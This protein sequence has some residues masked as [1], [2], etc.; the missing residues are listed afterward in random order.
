MD[1]RRLRA[2]LA[3]F[4]VES[5]VSPIIQF[6]ERETLERVCVKVHLTAA[7]LEDEFVSLLREQFAD[8]ASK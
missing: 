5:H 3:L 2:F 8:H 6:I 1:C 7:F 4:N